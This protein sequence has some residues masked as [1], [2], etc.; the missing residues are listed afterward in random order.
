MPV[1]FLV[2]LLAAALFV[3]VTA[4]QLPEA[5]ATH[6]GAGNLADGW[7]TRAGYRWYMLAFT[8]VFPL[9]LV[10]LIGGL[11]RVFPRAVNIPHRRYWLAPARRR[12]TLD[13]LLRHGC[14]LGCLIELMIVGTHLAILDAHRREP[15]TLSLALFLPLLGLFAVGFVA[16]IGALYRRFRRPHERY[17]S[18]MGLPM[19]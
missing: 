7:M 2:C 1:V 8:V 17:S 15:P 18:G 5:V 19:A 12:A 3:H 16:W 13:F 4:A 9:F 11:P 6:F 10:V 14:S